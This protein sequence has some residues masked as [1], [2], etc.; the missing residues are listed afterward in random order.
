MKGGAES[1]QSERDGEPWQLLL[2]SIPQVLS[3]GRTVPAENARE[4]NLVGAIQET[5]VVQ[6]RFCCPTA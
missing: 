6:L 4:A 1:S 3:Y 5:L 2:P